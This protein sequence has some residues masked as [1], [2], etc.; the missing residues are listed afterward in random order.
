[1][2]ASNSTKGTTAPTNTQTGE[3]VSFS[4]D[5]ARKSSFAQKQRMQCLCGA[6]SSTAAAN[7]VS[8]APYS[9]T[10]A[11]T[12]P[13]ISYNKRIKSLIDYGLVAGITPTS[14]RKR[15]P[16]GTLDFA[17]FR[18]DGKDSNGAQDQDS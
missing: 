3:S 16:Q 15:S 7:A 5:Q 18:Q 10:K 14:I 13:R 1:M 17:L 11:H 6:D 2:T 9:E 4:P 8:T 12:D